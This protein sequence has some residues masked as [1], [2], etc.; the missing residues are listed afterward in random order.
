MFQE[1]LKML[2]FFNK[3]VGTHAVVSIY[4]TFRNIYVC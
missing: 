4:T 1:M 3:L 2:L